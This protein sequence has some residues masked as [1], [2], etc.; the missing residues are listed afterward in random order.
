[1]RERLVPEESEKNRNRI[2]Q[3]REEVK[4]EE[5]TFDGRSESQ[6]KCFRKGMSMK[7]LIINILEATAFLL[8]GLGVSL[9]G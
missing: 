5:T 2:L 3:G 7:N 6:F 4:N 1:M 8:L 9:L